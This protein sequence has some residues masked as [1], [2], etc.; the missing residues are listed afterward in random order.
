MTAAIYAARAGISTKIL[1]NTGAGGQI[2]LTGAIDN[3]PGFTGIC[4]AEL[5]TALQTQ[6]ESCGAE[7]IY[8][9]ITSMSLQGGIKTV[10]CGSATVN[11]K[12]AII[13]TGASPRKIGC[14]GED[15]FIGAGVHFCA[16]CDGPFYKD[17]DIV[18]VG[19]GNSAVEEILYMSRIAK[20]ITV[21]NNLPDFTAF[22]TLVQKVNAM[23]D[24]TVLHNTT[25]AEIFGE[26]KVEGVK[27]NT[28]AKIKC[29]GVFVAIGRKPNSELLG[30][31]VKLAA[32]GYITVNQKFETSI[33]GVYAAGDVI[34]KS[35]RQIVTACADGACAAT[36]AVD[37]LRT[38]T[39]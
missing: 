28:G 37:Y 14:L 8:D 27:T 11:A 23:S 6:T 24:I 9:E 36:H 20:S 7:I 34:E 4:G 15:K 2:L 35:V 26:G 16:L 22:A 38:K 31:A 18:L 13:A 17:K 32:G 21:I 33:P 39:W 10:V 19:G 3:Y 25:V 1:E 29:D 30:G 12:A 5:A